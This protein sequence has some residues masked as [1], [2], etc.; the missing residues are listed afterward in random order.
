M[1]WLRIAAVLVTVIHCITLSFATHSLGKSLSDFCIASIYSDKALSQLADQFSV[2]DDV[3]LRVSCEAL[4]RGSFKISTQW[5]DEQGRL[6]A[7][8]VHTVEIEFPR[9]HSASFKFKQ[10]PQGTMKRVTSG[11]DF[12]EYQYGRWSVLTFINTDII[13]RNFFT[14]TE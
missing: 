10:M 7:E 8:R 6:Q 5:M 9:G 11:Q 1:I 12:E 14:I 13:G 2:Y 4:P 3:Y